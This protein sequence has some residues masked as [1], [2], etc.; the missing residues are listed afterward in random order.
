MKNK[1]KV[2]IEKIRQWIEQD[3]SSLKIKEELFEHHSGQ[4]PSPTS[5]KEIYGKFAYLG[6]MDLIEDLLK[7]SDL[8]LPVINYHGDKSKTFREKVFFEFIKGEVNRYVKLPPEEKDNYLDEHGFRLKH[9]FEV[10]DLIPIPLKGRYRF[11]PDVDYLLKN[12]DAKTHFPLLDV[13]FNHY[14]QGNQD[15]SLRYKDL[16]HR[17]DADYPYHLMTMGMR[18]LKQLDAAFTFAPVH[19]M[20]PE[21]AVASSWLFFLSD[22]QQNF[23]RKESLEELEGWLYQKIKEDLQEDAKSI[24]NWWS[25]WASPSLLEGAFKKFVKNPDGAALVL[26]NTLLKVSEEN[27]I[28]Y[29]QI[30]IYQDSETSY[31][32]K[33]V[34]VKI[35][36]CP[37]SVTNWIL[38]QDVKIGLNGVKLAS[39][40]AKNRL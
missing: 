3:Y 5:L 11:H 38:Q 36:C 17:D 28:P 16:N 2:N 30:T 21:K 8:K 23:T 1:V 13:V 25:F 7:F 35:G 10:M 40:P 33:E 15:L 6:R 18:T 19:K 20:V 12:A 22:L 39:S 31:K 9:S 34:F 32:F 24:S 14:Y 29:Q 27:H 4:A 26:M 37:Q